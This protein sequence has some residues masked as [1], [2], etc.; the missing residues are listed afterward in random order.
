[1]IKW[2]FNID[3]RYAVIY[4]EGVLVE[5]VGPWAEDNPDGPAIWAESL[6]AFRNENPNWDTEE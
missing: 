1:M 5:R 3:G 6:C 2:T 4:K